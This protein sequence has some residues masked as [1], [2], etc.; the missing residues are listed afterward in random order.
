M[1]TG[2]MAAL[3]CRAWCWAAR[4]SRRSACHCVD[5]KIIGSK[6][7]TDRAYARALLFQRSVRAAVLPAAAAFADVPCVAHWQLPASG[8]FIRSSRWAW[9]ACMHGAPPAAGWAWAPPRHRQPPPMCG[10]GASHQGNRQGS[11]QSAHE[12]EGRVSPVV[13][14]SNGGGIRG[15]RRS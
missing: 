4:L 1:G 14:L 3:F 12:G 5:L 15:K 6:T 11:S 9:L 13:E 10:S 2:C 8:A 7:T